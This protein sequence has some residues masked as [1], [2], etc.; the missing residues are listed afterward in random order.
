MTALEL[1]LVD[2]LVVSEHVELGRSGDRVVMI[3]KH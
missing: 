1:V 2:L 3:N